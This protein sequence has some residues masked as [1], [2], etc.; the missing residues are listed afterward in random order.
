MSL[1]V[2]DGD[3]AV[4]SVMGPAPTPDYRAFPDL[5]PRPVKISLARRRFSAGIARSRR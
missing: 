3:D 4:F 2:S 5:K 1:L